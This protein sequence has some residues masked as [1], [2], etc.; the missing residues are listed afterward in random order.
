MIDFNQDDWVSLCYV[1]D[2]NEICFTKEYLDI[3]GCLGWEARKFASHL[4]GG[5]DSEC[6]SILDYFGP[7]DVEDDWYTG[8]DGEPMD[9]GELIPDT[10]EVRG[11]LVD[12]LESEWY[13]DILR[14][15]LVSIKLPKKLITDYVN[16]LK[17]K[18]KGK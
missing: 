1:D 6:K 9:V 4:I 8:I 17:S 11:V 10:W 16:L 7:V 12:G 2:N 18:Q 3:I 13:R 5:W 15:K 14:A